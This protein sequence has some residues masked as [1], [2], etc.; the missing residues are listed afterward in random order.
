MAGFEDAQTK[1]AA[2][3]PRSLVGQWRR[4]GPFGPRYEVL[5]IEN[6]KLATVRVHTSGEVTSYPIAEVFTDPVD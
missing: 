4:F 2:F 5:T 1:Y 6:E 3:D